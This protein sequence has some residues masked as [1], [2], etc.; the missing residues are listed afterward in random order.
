LPEKRNA[1]SKTMSRLNLLA[2]A[3]KEVDEKSKALVDVV[4][5]V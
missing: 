3:Q 1:S 5:D 4:I 2:V